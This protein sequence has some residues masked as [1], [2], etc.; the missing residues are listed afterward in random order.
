MKSLFYVVVINLLLFSLLQSQSYKFVALDEYNETPLPIDSIEVY[1]FATGETQLFKSDSIYISSKTGIAEEADSEGFKLYPNPTTGILNIEL[2]QTLN[3]PITIS[4]I[5]GKMLFVGSSP[6]PSA[7]LSLNVSSLPAGMYNVTCGNR[8]GI[9]VKAGVSSGQEISIVSSNS[10]SPQNSYKGNKIQGKF[11]YRVALYSK[12]FRPYYKY[13]NSGE[14]DTT[15]TVVMSA[16]P[17]G[18]SNRHVRI[19]IYANRLNMFGKH[20]AHNMPETY[21]DTTYRSPKYVLMDTLVIRNGKCSV[22]KYPKDYNYG[23]ADTLINGS[24]EFNID[25]LTQRI[26]GFKTYEDIIERYITSDSYNTDTYYTDTYHYKI[27]LGDTLSYE[28]NDGGLYIQYRL[29]QLG[30]YYLGLAN[31]ASY[32]LGGGCGGHYNDYSYKL[33]DAGDSYVKIEFVD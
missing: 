16:L 22:K 19:E 17:D 13:F 31:S 30:R 11:D 1:N 23:F 12:G 29:G 24:L 18:F 32:V 2:P 20:Y 21:Y 6:A 26:W 10:F 4:D 9:F 27:E 15:I 28:A 7:N 5:N 25:T 3:L 33:I 14:V 8:V